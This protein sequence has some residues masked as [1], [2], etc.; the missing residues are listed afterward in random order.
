MYKSFRFECFVY[1]ELFQ[2][3]FRPSQTAA[4]KDCVVARDIADSILLSLRRITRAI[5]QHNKQLSDSY[6]LTVPQL[7]CLRHLLA[8]GAGTTGQLAKGACL[9]QATVTGIVD[10]LEA[11]GLVLRKR[12]DIDRR[13]QIV[14]LTDKGHNLASDMPWP[15]QE[16]FA[17]ALAAL[18][19]EDLELIDATLQR[20]VGMMEAPDVS[21]WGCDDE[22]V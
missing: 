10:R 4:T 8:H 18:E 22:H 2:A 5:D 9:S 15:L 21:P 1:K 3:L 7:V 6:K 16:R 11:K 13:K 20:L 19:N 12:S 14:S 17:R